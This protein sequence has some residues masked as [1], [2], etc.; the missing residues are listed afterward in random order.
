MP[1]ATRYWVFRTEGHA[2]C[3]FGKT[4]IAD[5]TGTTFTDTQVANGRT[6]YYNVVAPG[7]AAGLLRPGEQLR[8][9]DAR[10]TGPPGSLTGAQ[11]TFGS[12]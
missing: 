10:H 8:H 1:G 11:T 2:G 12:R 9:G 7:R 6:Y 5:V 4:R 3:N